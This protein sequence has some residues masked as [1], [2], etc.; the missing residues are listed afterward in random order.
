MKEMSIRTIVKLWKEFQLVSQP[1]GYD[2]MKGIK[3][4]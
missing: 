4:L 1:I 2:R 3:N